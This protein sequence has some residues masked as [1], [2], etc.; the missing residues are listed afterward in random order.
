[1]L[2]PEVSRIFPALLPLLPELT[3]VPAS[4]VVAPPLVMVMVPP[5]P[6]AEPR[7]APEM[8]APG[9]LDAGPWRDT[10]PPAVMVMLPPLLVPCRSS[11]YMALPAFM[12][13]SP[14]TAK[15]MEQA[16]LLPDPSSLQL[17]VPLTIRSPFTVKTP[18][19]T[20]S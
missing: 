20:W 17:I 7:A 19:T 11:A 12:T 8:T 13:T 14:L 5:L 6:M 10:L 18:L 16:G 2:P 1:M 9:R 15:L 3:T 4:K